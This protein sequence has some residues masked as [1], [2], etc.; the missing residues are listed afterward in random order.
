VNTYA[1]FM[2]QW[3]FGLESAKQIE[4]KIDYR[5]DPKKLR[6]AGVHPETAH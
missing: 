4:T 6:L 5:F 1:K 3:N 2:L